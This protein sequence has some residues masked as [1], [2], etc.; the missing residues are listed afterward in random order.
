MLSE[1]A[2]CLSAAEAPAVDCPTM[3]SAYSRPSMCLRVL[4]IDF[5]SSGYGATLT[6]RGGVVEYCQGIAER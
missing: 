5:T 2:T 1:R 4:G 6:K 3:L